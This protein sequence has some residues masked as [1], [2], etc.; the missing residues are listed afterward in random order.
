MPKQTVGATLECAGNGR[1]HFARQVDGEVRWGDCAVSTAVWGGV[2]VANLIK[3]AGIGEND[4]NEIREMIFL[5]A[6]GAW[7][8]SVPLESKSKF[9]R[10]L[11]LWKAMD[12][13]TLVALEMNGLPLSKN[14]GFPARIVV[15]GWYAMAS[16][17]WVT[18]I[19]LS[20]SVSQFKGYFNWTKYVYET[21]DGPNPSKEPV[22][23]LRVKSLITFPEEG[24]SFPKDGS[25]VVSGK[26]WSGFGKVLRVEVDSGEGWREA[27]LEEKNLGDYAWRSWQFEWTPRKSGAA[28]LRV[29]ATD[30]KGNTQP[31]LPQSNKYLYGYNAIHQ[32]HVK[33]V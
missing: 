11:P 10:S 7:D 21:E 2:P 3:Q 33:I 29:R 6:D 18:K 4:L 22:R 25:L 1:K 16:V 31:E 20:S 28:V 13:Q 12:Q 27:S 32:V 30:E 9:V 24:D 19:I 23:E 26:A 17:K 15:P 14:H 5:G 8:D